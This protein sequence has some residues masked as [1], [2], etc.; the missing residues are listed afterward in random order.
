MER[1]KTLAMEEPEI[2]ELAQVL[3]NFERGIEGAGLHQLGNRYR[4]WDIDIYRVDDV[5]F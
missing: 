1:L 3:R 2:E 5:S 4:R